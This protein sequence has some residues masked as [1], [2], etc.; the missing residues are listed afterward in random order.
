MLLQLDGRGG[1]GQPSQEVSA[2]GAEVGGTR[3]HGTLVSHCRR[4]SSARPTACTD[5]MLACNWT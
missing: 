1:E 5:R 3:Q 2:G 4:Q